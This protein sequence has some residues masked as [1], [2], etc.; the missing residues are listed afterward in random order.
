MPNRSRGVEGTDIVLLAGLAGILA[1]EV[2]SL[3][4]MRAALFVTGAHS[5]S[6]PAATAIAVLFHLGASGWPHGVADPPRAAYLATLVVEGASVVCGV[7][8]WRRRRHQRGHRAGIPASQAARENAEVMGDV[9]LP[10]HAPGLAIGRGAWSRWD[11]PCLVVGPPGMG[12]T[13]WL[14]ANI[15]SYPGPFIATSVKPELVSLT[16]GLLLD[17]NRPVYVLDVGGMLRLPADNTMAWSPT[18][19][20]KDL[21]R[22]R[23]QGQRFAFGAGYGA[24]RG[25]GNSAYFEGKAADVLAALF[26]AADIAG[27]DVARVAEWGEIPLA[28]K[29]AV[30]VL[31][32]AGHPREAAL[33]S[34]TLAS[35]RH[36]DDAHRSSIAGGVA[37][38]LAGLAD[39]AI[40]AACSPARDARFDVKAFIEGRGGI[41]VVGGEAHQE[42]AA[43]VIAAMIE[44]VLDQAREIAF[45]LRPPLV[46]FLDEA[47]NIAPL[48]SLPKLLATGRGQGICPVVCVQAFA[49]LQAT[50]GTSGAATLR[51]SAVVELSFGGAKDVAYLRSLAEFGGE[52][53][54]ETRSVSLGETT[55]RT[56]GETRRQALPIEALR[57]LPP[58]EAWLL[59]RHH[60]P[61]R[62]EV[63]PWWEGPLSG[64]VARSV[65][66]T[67]SWLREEDR[68]QAPAGVALRGTRER[69]RSRMAP[70][71]SR[72]AARSRA[73]R[74]APRTVLFGAP[75]P[76][77]HA[78]Q[79]STDHIEP[80]RW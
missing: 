76:R 9:A 27:V 45:P 22:A 16:A 53:D 21:R 67:A 68:P 65:E 3:V 80:G 34:D 38:A 75:R 15:A 19:G 8:A 73:R 61:R 54:V 6:V 5:P 18:A 43:T 63:P 57:A 24:R 71:S 23:L 77:T 1:A 25:E 49:Q 74:S 36:A 59:Y 51:E 47:A 29:E 40:A 11:H 4:A 69:S 13:S 2:A 55:T 14:V 78:E 28:T 72:A 12:K 31:R 79:R 66:A 48:R 52:I 62:V 20:C 33:L 30:Q 50:Y 58:H 37:R 42:A 60:T 41:Y 70:A 17:K 32:D 46:C 7:C 44:D 26:C 64:A 56:I 10:D 35:R 39:P